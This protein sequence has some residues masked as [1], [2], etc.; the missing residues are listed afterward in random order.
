MVVA[1]RTTLTALLVALLALGLRFVALSVQQNPH[2]A[3]AI[4]QRFRNL[5]I[6]QDAEC[7]DDS[8]FR[9]VLARRT[10]R[11]FWLEALARIKR[12]LHT[13]GALEQI[14]NVCIRYIF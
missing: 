9:Q 10:F 6:V 7:I 11:R 5:E 8:V 3:K 4:L 12:V 2:H 1:L 13:P 14:F